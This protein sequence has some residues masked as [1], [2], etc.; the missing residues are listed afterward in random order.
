VRQAKATRLVPVAVLGTGLSALL[1]G[2]ALLL[3]GSQLPT[4]TMSVGQ[5]VG[6]LALTLFLLAIALDMADEGAG[7]RP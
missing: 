6:I 7:N 2:A 1:V 3:P 4:V 5:G